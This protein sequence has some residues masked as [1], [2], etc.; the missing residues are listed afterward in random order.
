MGK[1]FQKFVSKKFKAKAGQVRGAGRFDKLF[2]ITKRNWGLASRLEH[3]R[4]R[5]KRK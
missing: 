4:N 5:G 3:I 2:S 1:I